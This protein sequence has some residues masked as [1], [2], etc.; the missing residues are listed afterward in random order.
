M[1]TKKVIDLDAQLGF[2]EP[3]EPLH[4]KTVSLFGREWTVVCDLNSFGMTAF[5]TGDVQ[6]IVELL[7]GLVVE[8]ER[9]DFVKALSRK[10]NLDAEKLRDIIN[11]LIEVA[12][13]VPT[14]QPSA[15]SRTATKRTSK[16]KSVASSSATR[17]RASTR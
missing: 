15:S 10:R 17:A 3:D 9:D 6:G 11:A 2:D 1:T 13:E 14:K 16:P 8:G 12:A 4:T 5:M 7:L